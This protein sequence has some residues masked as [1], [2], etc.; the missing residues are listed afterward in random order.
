MQP[1]PCRSTEEVQS[2]FGD[3][4]GILCQ[5]LTL[6]YLVASGSPLILNDLRATYHLNTFHYMLSQMSMMQNPT[7]DVHNY[8]LVESFE[9]D[10]FSSVAL[11]KLYSIIG[12]CC[13]VGALHVQRFAMNLHRPTRTRPLFQP[14]KESKG[15]KRCG[16]A[17]AT[18]VCLYKDILER[19]SSSL[20]GKYV[21]PPQAP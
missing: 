1:H 5:L 4:L 9:E 15:R 13:R 19:Q 17:A 3:L 7:F 10:T 14:L 6:C 18:S 11:F 21:A 8:G 12:L 20:F 16:T 2:K